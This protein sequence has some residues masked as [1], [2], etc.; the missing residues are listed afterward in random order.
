MTFSKKCR[1]NLI[2]ELC[3]LKIHENYKTRLID[4]LEGQINKIQ[5]E[6]GMF[7]VIRTC[8]D[9]FEMEKSLPNDKN[10]NAT[11][12]DYIGEAPF[13]E[14]CYDAFDNIVSQ[15]GSYDKDRPNY[16]LTEIPYFQ[17]AREV[18]ER[19]IDDFLSLPRRYVAIFK[20]N[21]ELSLS[22]KNFYP[23]EL[24]RNGEYF[25]LL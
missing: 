21:K 1:G 3:V 10:L 13:F 15:Y 24:R 14:F 20:L 25:I 19:I 22:F 4:I 16:M 8:T 9:L 11:I 7:L 12:E 5:V 18:A 17:N 23:R 6:K 2:W